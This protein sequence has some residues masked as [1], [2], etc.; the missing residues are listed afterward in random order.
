VSNERSV[1]FLDVGGPIYD[2]RVY[3]DALRVGLRAGGADVPD[4]EFERE[5]ERCRRAQD[6]FTRPLARRFGVDPA[7]LERAA[8]AAWR[9][10]SDAMYADVL[11]SLRRVAAGFA[12]GVLANQPAATR[13]A[14]E[15]DGVAPFVEHWVLSGDLGLSKPDPR[16]FAHA[17]GVG[18]R[19]PERVAYVGN[20]LDNDVRPAR[21]AGMRTV[22]LLRGEAPAAPTA[23]QRAEADAVIRSLAELPD[24]LEQIGLSAVP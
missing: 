5:Y 8:A 9:Y 19:P 18:G 4:A 3:A 2:D 20:R 10:P 12:I 16:L 1:V 15:R 7:V 14:L 13:A 23:N 6:G 22:W 17:I 24:A 21:A 11:P